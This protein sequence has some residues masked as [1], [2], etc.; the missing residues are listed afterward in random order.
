MLIK[1]EIEPELGNWT[2]IPHPYTQKMQKTLKQG[3]AALLR[4]TN[5]T[6]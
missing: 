6:K 1:F 3:K 2:N 5:I 4:F